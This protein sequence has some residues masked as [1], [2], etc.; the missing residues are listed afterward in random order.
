[1]AQ[2]AWD[3]GEYEEVRME[4]GLVA[5]DAKK[6]ELME[7]CAFNRG[8]LS[9]H[10]L[11]AT[12]TTGTLIEHEVGLAIHRLLS[13]PRGGDQEVGAMIATGRLDMLFFFWDPETPQP[14]DPDVKALLRLATLW[15]T[16]TACNSATADMIISS[17]LFGD[18]Y[19][20]HRPDSFD[21]SVVVDEQGRI[22]I[23]S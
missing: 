18:D 12:G 7:W 5:H 11:W 20:P 14:H 23:D 8:T 10:E 4:I 9:Q 16:P 19:K 3:T 2:W 17:P 22:V 15:N 1:M 21:R 6:G 13:G